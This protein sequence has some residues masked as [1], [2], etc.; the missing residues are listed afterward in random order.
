M[1]VRDQGAGIPEESREQIFHRFWRGPDRSESGSGLGLAIVR[2]TAKA[3]GGTIT[4][5][6][7]L[8]GGVSFTLSLPLMPFDSS[9]VM[10]M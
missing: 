5:E 3:H 8:S 2:E 9:T 4:F 7:R 10:R 6:N 1:S